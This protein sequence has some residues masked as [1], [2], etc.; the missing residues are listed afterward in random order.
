MP[1][2]REPG[3]LCRT[4]PRIPEKVAFQRRMD[5][6]PDV[7]RT[8]NAKAMRLWSTAQKAGRSDREGHA[9]LAGRRRGRQ[10]PAKRA[11]PVAG[12]FLS[13]NE[14][15]APLGAKRVI[16]RGTPCGVS[17]RP[18]PKADGLRIFEAG[19]VGKKAMRLWSKRISCPRSLRDLRARAGSAG[20]SGR[21]L[22]TPLE[23]GRSTGKFIGPHLQV[24]CSI[25]RSHPRDLASSPS[26]R[27]PP[28][29]RVNSNPLIPDNPS[30]AAP[31][32]PRPARRAARGNP[33]AG[34][35]PRAGASRPTPRAGIQWRVRIPA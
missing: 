6:E 8:K 5:F 1:K 4:S 21:K 22:Y 13:L 3:F 17:T 7:L 35:R 16:H 31:G 2:V 29:A 23:R 20:K 10:G 18:P 14:R 32:R 19:I 15:G 26:S 27:P 25:R 30:V 24:R 12:V 33:G 11:A 28:R 9:P 34:R